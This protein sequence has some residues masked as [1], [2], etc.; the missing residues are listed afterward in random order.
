MS[1]PEFYKQDNDKVS[2]V[3]T[4][5]NELIEELEANETTWLNAQNC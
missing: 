5:Y 1:A 4:Q 3:Q 2:A